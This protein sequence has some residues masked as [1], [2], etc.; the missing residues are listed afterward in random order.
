MFVQVLWQSNTERS[1]VFIIQNIDTTLGTGNCFQ[2]CVHTPNWGKTTPCFS[3]KYLEQSSPRF[4]KDSGTAQTKMERK[5]NST[6]KCMTNL[7]IQNFIRFHVPHLC[8][9]RWG[10]IT[11][12]EGLKPTR[13]LWGPSGTKAQK[14]LVSWDLPRVT[15]SLAQ[16]W[17]MRNSHGAQQVR[18]R[19]CHC[20]GVTAEAQVTAVGQVQSLAWEFPHAADTAKK[21]KEEELMIESLKGCRHVMT[22]IAVKPRDW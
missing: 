4:C 2:L 3:R 12:K 8:L 18:V 1:N 9:F 11:E 6:A 16:E 22:K 10:D 20:R 13:T 17:M 14:A 19:R 5:P 7:A 21:K 15:N